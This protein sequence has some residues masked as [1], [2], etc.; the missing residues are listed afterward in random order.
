MVSTEE[1]ETVI[2]FNRNDKHAIIYTSDST[3]MTKLDKIC[4]KAPE[5]YKLISK[6]K[7]R[8]GKIVG[9]TY[10]LTDKKMLSF[11]AKKRELILTEEEKRKFVERI[12]SR[13]QNF[14]E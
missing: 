5:N 4:A 2:Q 3:T 11:R 12:S 14:D 8:D 9:K 13:N 1:Q 10:I 7:D 6:D